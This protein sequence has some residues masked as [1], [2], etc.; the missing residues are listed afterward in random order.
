M[1]I[2]S[3]RANDEKFR[4]E[5]IGLSSRSFLS[6]RESRYILIFSDILTLRTASSMELI[7]IHFSNNL[8]TL[9][10]R[11]PRCIFTWIMSR[12][13][14]TCKNCELY[15]NPSNHGEHVSLVLGDIKKSIITPVFAPW[16]L[17][18]NSSVRFFPYRRHIVCKSVISWDYLIWIFSGFLP[19]HVKYSSDNRNSVDGKWI[20]SIWHMILDISSL[21]E[22]FKR[23]H[24]TH[25]SFE[26]RAHLF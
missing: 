2:Y 24:V 12:D 5:P 11:P 8:A 26:L 16:V 7:S 3:T 21:L 4:I 1:S 18:D 14:W 17:H 23:C 20:I 22:P 25:N 13:L 9:T 15:D 10:S 19:V 6:T